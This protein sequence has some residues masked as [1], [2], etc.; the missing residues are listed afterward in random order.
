MRFS[1]TGWYLFKIYYFHIRLPAQLNKCISYYR[2]LNEEYDS[3]S[4]SRLWKE[5]NASVEGHSLL[6]YDT[7]LTLNLFVNHQGALFQKTV[8]D[9]NNDVET[10]NYKCHVVLISGP[11]F[12]VLIDNDRLLKGMLFVSFWILNFTLCIETFRALVGHVMYLPV[13]Y[14]GTFTGHLGV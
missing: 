9:T 5:A 1:A 10:I 11:H 6:G 14:R 13:V 8:V 12:C 7:L 2:S 3:V 4:W